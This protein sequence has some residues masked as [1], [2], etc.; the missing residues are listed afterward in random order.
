MTGGFARRY[1]RSGHW[2]AGRRDPRV[3]AVPAETAAALRVERAALQSCGE[4]ALLANVLLAGEPGGEPN[5]HR[6]GPHRSTRWRAEVFL[7]PSPMPGARRQ[8]RPG[9]GGGKVSGPLARRARPPAQQLQRVPTA[10]CG[11][12]WFTTERGKQQLG[13]KVGAVAMLAAIAAAL[14]FLLGS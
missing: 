1:S 6:P 4:P 2:A 11:W 7:E 10:A 14:L 5:L 9:S 12:R 3:G 8:G 13:A